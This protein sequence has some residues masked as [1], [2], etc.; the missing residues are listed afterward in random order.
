MARTE[1]ALKAN[2]VGLAQARQKVWQL[3]EEWEK[4]TTRVER[5][6]LASHII[7]WKLVADKEQA[8]MDKLIGRALAR[9]AS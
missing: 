9:L 8:T 5:R 1:G 7:R 3:T 2:R 6:R 4:A